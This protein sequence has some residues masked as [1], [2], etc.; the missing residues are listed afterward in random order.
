[1]FSHKRYHPFHPQ[2]LQ[3]LKDPGLPASSSG[4]WPTLNA[5][6]CLPSQV[7]SDHDLYSFIW[8]CGSSWGL[9]FGCWFIDRYASAISRR[10]NS[11]I[12]I[13]QPDGGY[14]IVIPKAE[15][16]NGKFMDR[17]AWKERFPTRLLPLLHE[18]RTIWRP[19]I[20]RQ[21]RAFQEY[22][23]LNSCGA[24]MYGDVLARNLGLMTARMT[25]DRP[26]VPW[27]GIPTSFAPHGRGRCSTRG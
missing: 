5:I 14:E 18:W 3:D 25:Q 27:R 4:I 10:C 19:R 1:M 8:R 7:V 17:K 26:A 23:F 12:C 2:R 11:G 22:V 24:S 9:S 13:K 21:D 20:Q 16:K 6:P 15:M